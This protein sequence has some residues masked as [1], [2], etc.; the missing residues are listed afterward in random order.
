MPDSSSAT[1]KTRA[2]LYGRVS[3]K[4]GDQ[5]PETQLYALREYVAN[6]GLQ[7]VAEY[8]DEASATNM[9]DRKAWRDLLNHV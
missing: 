4:D 5:N 2:A 6:R 9:R 1:A 8:V 3:T 7:I